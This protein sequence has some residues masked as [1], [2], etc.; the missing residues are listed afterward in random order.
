MTSMTTL[1]LIIIL[2]LGM[3]AIALIG[4]ITLLLPE[5]L[6]NKIILPLV[7]LAA[8]T[9]IGGAMFHLLPE[10]ISTLGNTLIVYQLLAFGFIS[11]F[12][13]EQF[14][15][16]HHCHRATLKHK[17]VSY[18]ILIADAFHN[19][20][21]GVA[22]GAAM[23]IDIKLG[24]ILW[25]ILAIHEIPQ[26]LGDF[27][28]LIHSGWRN[29]SALYYNFMSALTFPIGAILAY[30]VSSNFSMAIALPFA[31]GSFLYIGAADLIPQLRATRLSDQIIQFLS[32]M[33]GL[34]VLFLLA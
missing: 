19:L 25:L 28:I 11:F 24:M 1:E 27:G 8:G 3:S 21:D 12:V 15:H 26:E 13:L 23:V 20:I 10:A 16:W 5:I 30:S 7:A 29:K 34:L 31:A 18:L 6:L 33:L 22:F 4:S 9:F 2:S 17:S 14:L 32:F